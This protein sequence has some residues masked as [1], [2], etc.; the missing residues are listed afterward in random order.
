MSGLLPVDQAL[1]RILAGAGPGEAEIVPLA[2]AAGRVLAGP[3]QALRT[4]P[5]FDASAMDGYAVRASDV[6]DIPACLQLVGTAAAGKL[7]PGEVGPGQAVR[8]FTGAPVPHGADT[9]AIQENVRPLDG[10]T[11]EVLETVAAGRHIRKRGLDFTDGE[12]LLEAGRTLDPAALSLAASANHPALPV[13]RKPLVALIATGD[14]LLPPGSATG[15]DQIIASNAY[16]VAAIAQQAGARVLDLGIAPDRIE[17]ISDLVRKALE[18]DADVIITLGGASVGDHDLV[19]TALKQ[20]GMELG[21]WKIAMRP[22]KPLMFGRLGHTRCLG[23][24]GNPV[25]SL[26]CS[27]L[28][29]S[30]LLARLGGRHYEAPFIDAVLGGTMAANDL[31]QDYVRATVE[32]LPERIVA[33]P[34]AIQDSSMLRLLA[35]AGGLIVREPFAPEVKAGDPCRVL[36]LR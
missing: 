9:I 29:L 21:F 26:V 12:T 7:F 30:P 14:E 16:G 25:A 15:P 28:F 13:V 33:T 24:P 27:Q 2:E 36:L 23:L 34:F 18:A 4:Q 20:I 31:R 11:I 19:H 17:A 5:P 8:I 6:A 35:D 32:F 1:A 3:I 22:G 10:D